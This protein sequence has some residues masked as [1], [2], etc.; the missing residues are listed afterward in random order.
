LCLNRRCLLPES[1]GL[2]SA[3]DL[4]IAPWIMPLLLTAVEI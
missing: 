3:V 1:L 2:Q 4:R